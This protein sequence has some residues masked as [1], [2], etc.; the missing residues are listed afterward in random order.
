M[1][2]LLLYSTITQTIQHDEAELARGIPTT[3]KNIIKID[4]VIPITSGPRMTLN[5]N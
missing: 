4:S 2:A 5:E 3:Y 1:I